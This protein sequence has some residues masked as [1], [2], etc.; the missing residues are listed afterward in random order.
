MK[1]AHTPLQENTP[2]HWRTELRSSERRLNFHSIVDKHQH[3]HF[4]TFNTVLV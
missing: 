2:S 4:L 1:T 3:M